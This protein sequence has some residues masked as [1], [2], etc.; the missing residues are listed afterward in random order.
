METYTLICKTLEYKMEKV[1]SN[2]CESIGT[3]VSEK[4]KRIRILESIICDIGFILKL[5]SSGE[6]LTSHGKY[7]LLDCHLEVSRED[8]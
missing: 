7:K 1:I 3:S 5:I 4:F 2:L 8:F 6:F